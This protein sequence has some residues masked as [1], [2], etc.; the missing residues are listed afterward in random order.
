M[1]RV[2]SPHQGHHALHLHPDFPPQSCGSMLPFQ[3]C[4]P[5]WGQGALLWVCGASNDITRGLS[6]E[7]DL[8]PPGAGELAL[9]WPLCGC[10]GLGR[11]SRPPQGL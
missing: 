1:P 11:P 4:L 2:N 8:I 3:V 6:Q 9:F 10:S 5:R 7:S